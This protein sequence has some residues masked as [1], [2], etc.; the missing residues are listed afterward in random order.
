[1]QILKHWNKLTNYSTTSKK[2][3]WP[4]KNNMLPS[5]KTQHPHGKPMQTLGHQPQCNEP[6]HE[7]QYQRQQST[8]QSHI[9]RQL[10]G[11]SVSQRR[12]PCSNKWNCITDSEKLQPTKRDYHTGTTCNSINKN[13]VNMYNSYTTT[14][15]ESTSI[16]GNLIEIPNIKR[17]GTHWQP[18]NLEESPKELVEEWKQ[19]TQSFSSAKTRSRKIEWKT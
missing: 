1:M 16:I 4:E 15:Q 8:N 9:R 10:Q 5:M 3:W 11:C 7:S 6:Q 14:K 19:P 2:R 18:M 12:I 13:N 17:Y